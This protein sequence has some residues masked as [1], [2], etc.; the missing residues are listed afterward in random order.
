MKLR[1]D[2]V[3]LAV[4]VFALFWIRMELSTS[5][6]ALSYDSYLSVRN[7]ENIIE[8]GKPLRFDDLSV[9]GS[10]RITNPVFD[11]L[12]A[13]LVL[14][15]P[16]MYKLLPN[17]FMALLLIPVFFI[18]LR[19]TQSRGAAL[20]AVMLAGTGPIVFS[21]YLNTPGEAPIALALFLA[22]L[23][24]IHDIDRHIFP[25]IIS[26][27]LLTFISPIVFIL[28]LSLLAII[29]LLKVEGFGLDERVN[30]LFYFTLVLGVW[31]YVI[32]YKQALF[33]HG[34][35]VLW[36][37]LPADLAL[38]SFGNITLL[39]VLYALGVV[40][41]LFG[42]F[43]VYHVLFE[44]R[45]RTSYS[46]IGAILAT[47]VM[48]L[49][50]TITVSLGL[51]ILA[52]L[53][54]I[55]AAYG[56]LISVRYVRLTKAPWMVYPIVGIIFVFF[57]FSAVF[58]ALI[59]ARLSLQ[60]S[61]T[62]EDIASMRQLGIELPADVVLLAPV[63]ESAAVQYFSGHQTVTD[64][65]FLLVERGDELVKDIDSVYTSSFSTA[66]MGKA[67]KLGF[68]HILLTAAAQRQYG[69]ERLLASDAFCLPV[70]QIGNIL[71]YTVVCGG[72][73]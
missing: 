14:L 58:P 31:F 30:E 11:Y 2:L 53:L 62:A 61:P 49:L 29:V 22:I 5:T 15:T 72:G 32:I 38:I 52:V 48:L 7:V 68:T 13:G 37:N 70:Q 50:R 19:V 40:T 66:V 57:V 26:T 67:N 63:K 23:A 47:I 36:Q 27:I 59:N 65:D 10:R 20:V 28:V 8:T 33:T 24:M 55:M 34:I 1:W 21:S 56:L 18:G 54:S 16:L 6:S 51:V 9:T 73:A 4:L 43:G 41:F 44:T 42:T 69:R 71:I 45:E 60:E 39:G 3:L 46:I 17:L 12:L 64:S 35:K 25:I